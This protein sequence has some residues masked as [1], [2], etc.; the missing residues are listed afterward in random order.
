[1][2]TVTIVRNRR[3]C[4]LILMVYLEFRHFVTYSIALTSYWRKT[5]KNLISILLLGACALAFTGC[6]SELTNQKL[7]WKATNDAKDFNLGNLAKHKFKVEAFQDARKTDPR[8]KIAENTEKE[9]PRI[10]T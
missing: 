4:A 3:I 1:M 10:V 5:L 8:N 9:T 2:V 7:F 6:A